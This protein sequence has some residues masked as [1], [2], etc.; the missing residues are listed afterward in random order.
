M[1]TGIVLEMRDASGGEIQAVAIL[2]RHGYRHERLSAP[3]KAAPPDEK[4]PTPAP[5]APAP[6]PKP[7]AT[8][9]TV[10]LKDGTT[11]EGKIVMRS[12]D[13]LLLKTSDGKTVKIE[14][15]NVSEVRSQPQ[16]PK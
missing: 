12:D 15:D 1:G 2:N 3:P 9:D 14:M 10:V 6:S 5:A 13:L 11:L 8:P 16:K 4:K 7:Q